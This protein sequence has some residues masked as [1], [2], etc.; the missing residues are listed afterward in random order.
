MLLPEATRLELPA[1]CVA[2]GG[3]LRFPF[4]EL[5]FVSMV[6]LFDLDWALGDV[7]PWEILVE[8]L[9]VRVVVDSKSRNAVERVRR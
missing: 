4:R 2:S 8:L 9:R 7:P 5:E 3:C 6:R 1:D